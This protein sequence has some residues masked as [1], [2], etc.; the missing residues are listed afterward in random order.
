MNEPQRLVV[1]IADWTVYQLALVLPD[2]DK[3]MAA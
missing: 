1:L 3:E 2:T